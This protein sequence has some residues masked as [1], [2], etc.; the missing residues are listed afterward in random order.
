MADP[1][2]RVHAVNIYVK[3][4]ARSLDFYQAFGLATSASHRHAKVPLAFARDQVRRLSRRSA[5][6]A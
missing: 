2:L 4:Q 5:E 6:G 3:D 1:Y